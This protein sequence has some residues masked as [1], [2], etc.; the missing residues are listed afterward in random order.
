MVALSRGNRSNLQIRKTDLWIAKSTTNWTV[1]LRESEPDSENVC[2]IVKS[3][4]FHS[5]ITPGVIENKNERNKQ[6]TLSD[7]IGESR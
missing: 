2:R 6:Y 4:R 5:N 7:E 3:T 1:Q